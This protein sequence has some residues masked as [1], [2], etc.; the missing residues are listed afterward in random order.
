VIAHVAAFG[1]LLGPQ[2]RCQA[3]PL[4]RRLSARSGVQPSNVLTTI[5]TPGSLRRSSSAIRG[6]GSMQ[7]SE[8]PRTANAAVALPVP[9]PTSGTGPGPAAASTSSTRRPG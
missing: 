2:T 4:I 1:E 5:G 8:T 7:M 9:A 3:W 6:S